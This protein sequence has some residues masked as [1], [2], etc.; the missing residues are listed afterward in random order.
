MSRSGAVGLH[1]VTGNP[2]RP[3]ERQGEDI[4][5][6]GRERPNSHRNLCEHH[7]AGHNSQHLP[8]SAAGQVEGGE[9]FGAFGQTPYESRDRAQSDERQN[10]VHHGPLEEPH[11][12]S[13]HQTGAEHALDGRELKAHG[14]GEAGAVLQF[15]QP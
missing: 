2:K 8:R 7:D 10:G 6:N 9:R 13:R 3:D 1:H 4:S 11:T 5:T 12:N 15:S 14:V